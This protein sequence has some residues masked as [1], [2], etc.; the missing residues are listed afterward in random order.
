[1]SRLWGGVHFKASLTAGQQL[2]RP[3]GDLAFEF[4]EQA[5]ARKREVAARAGYLVSTAR[6]VST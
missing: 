3:I 2:C 1:M 5:S 4:V 6:C